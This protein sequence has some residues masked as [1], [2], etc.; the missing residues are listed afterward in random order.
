MKLSKLFHN[1]IGDS[2]R[3]EFRRCLL[4]DNIRRGK[5]L[6]IA[7]I[8]FECV[9]ALVDIIALLCKADSRFHYNRYL[10]MY[11]VLIAV[12][13]VYLVLLKP[14]KGFKY[15]DAQVRRL[16]FCFI[17]YM[18]VVMSWGSVI[19]L[20]DQKL[21]GQI[22]A[23]IIN[24]VICS[25]VY[26][27]DHK[28]ILVPYCISFLV[29]AVGLPF[30]QHSTD[31]LI[32]HYANLLVVI[33]VAW[34]ASR[35][36][37][38]GYCSNFISRVM[39]SQSKK[40]LEDEVEENKQINEKL[41]QANKQLMVLTLHDDLTGIP[42]RRSFRDFI[43]RSLDQYLRDQSTFSVIMLDI[44]YFKQFNDFYGHEAGDKALT[45]IAVQLQSVS[46]H[47]DEFA[48]RW[49]GEEFLYAAFSKSPA[50]IEETASAIV[51][52]ILGLNICHQNSP[53]SQFITASLG[54]GTI[55]LRDKN[56][57]HRAIKL[58]DD[59]LYLAKSSGRNC[60]KMLRFDSGPPELASGCA[61]TAPLQP[62]A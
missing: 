37:Y 32:G 36:I 48:V 31:I 52:K 40:L 21:Y 10:I 54:I 33:I 58:A 43:D 6:A 47:P 23:F 49:G 12:N 51:S 5:I 20:M 17:A 22:T 3:A 29:L 24:M 2:D 15:S 57:I 62:D 60:T 38:N 8:A 1:K 26:V 50:D 44:D 16:E 55:R 27:L 34:L 7:I 56:D 30:L 42:N 25:V 41:A 11:M 14:N 35:I 4:I 53:V 28:S 46:A 13:A 39:L 9:Y 19:T 18:T 59:A 61:G 45:E